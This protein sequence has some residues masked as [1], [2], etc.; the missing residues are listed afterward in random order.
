MAENGA[1]EKTEEPTP[2][3][4]QDS[5]KKGVVAKSVE[6]QGSLGLLA[7]VSALPA[8]FGLFGAQL[9]EAFRSS[10]QHIPHGL[11]PSEVSGFTGGFAKPAMMI[12]LAV[13]GLAMAVGLLTNFA[14]VG[15]MISGEAI[16]PKFSK[17]NPLEGFKRLFSRRSVV[18]GLKTIFKGGLFGWIAYDTIQQNWVDL[19]RLSWITPGVAAT[20]VGKMIGTVGM[21]VGIAWLI[22]AAVDYFFQKK[23]VTKQLMMSKD[24]LKREMKEQEGSPEIRA[25]RMQRM[26]KLARGR[27][28]EAIQQADVIITNPTHY[29]VAI[30]YDRDSMHAPMVVAKGQDYLALKIREIATES[31]IP[32]VPNPPLARALY[33]Q[34]EIGDFVPREMFAAVAEVLAYVYRAIKTLR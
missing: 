12:F 20:E 24:E 7:M 18:E 14:Q 5:R 28:K 2:K 33:K 9:L 8:I 6:V 16:Q 10:M 4:R 1:G 13:A 29:A 32:I 23:E 30:K 21:R 34:C 11:S 25:A 3:K 17:L 19:I 31:R 15:F 27:T 26:R 22:M